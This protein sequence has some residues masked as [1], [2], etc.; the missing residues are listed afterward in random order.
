MGKTILAMVL[1][2]IAFVLGSVLEI[3]NHI[4]AP[5]IGIA[6]S[7]MVMG[8]CIIYFNEKK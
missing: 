2:F 4:N 7:V 8:G 3:E 6:L 1:T 5:G